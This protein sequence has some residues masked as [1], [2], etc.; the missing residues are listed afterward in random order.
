MLKAQQE[1]VLWQRE[2]VLYWGL[3]ED[4]KKKKNVPAFCKAY[5]NF[6]SASFFILNMTEFMQYF[7]SLEHT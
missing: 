1:D 6:C 3:Y 5:S 4:C 2:G 7:Y